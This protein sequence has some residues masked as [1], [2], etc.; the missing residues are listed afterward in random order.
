MRGTYV[1]SPMYSDR[2]LVP[3]ALPPYDL[4]PARKRG[5]EPDPKHHVK[6]VKGREKYAWVKSTSICPQAAYCLRV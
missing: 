3:E 5:E 2:S 6:D 1:V 4:S